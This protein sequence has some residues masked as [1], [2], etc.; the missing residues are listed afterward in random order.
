MDFRNRRAIHQAAAD[1]V[2]R[3]G[4]EG[5]KLFLCYSGTI[6]A[7]SLLSLAVSYVLD[8]R[9]AETGGLSNMGLRSVLSTVQYILPIAQVIISTCLGFSY[10]QNVLSMAR[11]Q[12]AD[13]RT[14]PYGFRHFFLLLRLALLEG[15]IYFAV[16][17]V[18]MQLSSIIFTFTPFAQ[19]YYEAVEPLV[20]SMSVLGTVPALDEATTNAILAACMPAVW[21]FLGVYLILFIPV[22]FRY[23]MSM[24]CLADEPRMGAFLA[25][26][27]SRL[28]LRKRCF[29]LLKLDLTMW[30]FYALQVLIS[31]VLYSDMLLPILG[32]QLPWNQNASMYLFNGFS[33][34]LQFAVYYFTLNRVNVTYAVAYDTLQQP[35]DPQ[36]AAEPNKPLPFQ[37]E[38]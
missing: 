3:A 34:L 4:K 10:Q 22:Y 24:F 8:L 12:S 25:L 33:V 16:G 20:D 38:F 28:M 15:L 37:T 26:H 11:G 17:F 18:S 2:N 13:C 36:K 31:L 1:A 21:I 35:R 5:K 32:I 30:W 29:D 9:I 23:R 19:A 27:K 7:L 6:T 14:L